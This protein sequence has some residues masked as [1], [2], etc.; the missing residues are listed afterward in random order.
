MLRYLTV[1]CWLLLLSGAAADPLPGTA[2]LT[3]EGDIPR[4]L[5]DGAHRFADRETALSVERRARHWKRDFSSPEAYEKSIQPN[6]ER[7]ARYLGVVNPRSKTAFISWGKKTALRSGFEVHWLTWPS[8]LFPETGIELLG[9]AIYFAPA[10]EPAMPQRVVI[11]LPDQDD[12]LSVV[13][14]LT[15][16]GCHVFIPRGVDRQSQHSITQRGARQLGVSHREFVYRQAFEMGRQVIG[17][18]IENLLSLL[19][20]LPNDRKFQN[21]PIGLLGSGDG[22]MTALYAAAIDPR[23]QA[24]GVCGYFGPREKMDEETIDRNVW[25]RFDE[26]GDAEIASLIIPRK[27]VIE[28]SPAATVVEEVSIPGRLFTPGKNLA[29]AAQSARREYERLRTLLGPHHSK[30]G[31]PVTFVESPAGLSSNTLQLFLAGLQA[32]SGGTIDSASVEPLP[33]SQF[34]LPPANWMGPHPVDQMTA[35]TQS[36][37]RES[38][39]VREEFF[40]NADRQSRDPAK[41][42]ASTQ[43]YK[44]YLYNEVIGRF[45]Y[46]LEKPNPRTRQVYDEEKYRGYE[47]VLDVFPDVIAYG[48][49]LLPKDLKPGEKRP[50]VVCQHGLEGRPQDTIEANQ[51]ERYYHR[52]AAKLA[53]RGFITFAP[54]NLY[55]FKNDFRQLQR[56]LNPLKKSL[57]SIIIPQHQQICDWLAALPMV[58]PDRIAF[59]GLSYGGKTAMRVPPLVDRYCAVICSGDFNEW[60]VKT[61]SVRHKFSYVGTGEYEIWEWNLGNTFNYAE[62]AGLIA[63]RPFMVERGHRDGVGLD[64]FV[65]YEYAKV[66]LLYADLKIPERTEIEYFDGPHE[67]HA[68]GTF[69]FLHKH[70]NWPEP[71]V[72]K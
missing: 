61:T 35:Y 36:L 29:P 19:D 40:K 22:A 2:P 25:G 3:M 56:K 21:L 34:K 66:Q 55:I 39:F 38:E 51:G 62:L 72:G 13:E 5:L 37:V 70:L 33:P 20:A 18:E 67:I 60:I 45:D 44:D 57:Y 47:V 46:P 43:W 49:L 27:L 28:A 48:V 6:R 65:A 9:E 10:S 15:K 52:F 8:V 30:L 42:E 26:F 41:W 23:I 32:K 4:Q 50:V 54:Q 59:Y 63:P 69:K 24:A 17:Y 31:N 58:D 1:S 16:S 14:Y 53:E 7:L 68:V 64:P 12:V 11:F 71:A